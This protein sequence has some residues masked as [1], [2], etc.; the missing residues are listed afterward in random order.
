M[1]GAGS[2]SMAKTLLRLVPAG[3]ETLTL[4]RGSECETCIPIPLSDID[5][6]FDALAATPIY[7]RSRVQCKSPVRSADPTIA[8]VTLTNARSISP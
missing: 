6:S 5:R 8:L 2:F 7:R 4:R 1:N 3:T